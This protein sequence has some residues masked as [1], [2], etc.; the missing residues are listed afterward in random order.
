M[1]RGFIGSIR[2]WTI[3]ESK[4]GVAF[5]GA[6]IVAE[7]HGRAIAANLNARLVGVYDPE[8]NRA[9]A[10]AKK[11]GAKAFGSIEEALDSPQVSAVHVLTPP[12]HHMEVALKSLKAGKH[13]LVEK[14]VAWRIADIKRLRTAAKRANRACMPAHNYIYNPSLQRAKR[15]IDENRL[16]QI[17]SLWVLYNIYHSEEVASRYG[18]VLRAVCVHHAYSLLYLLGR[19]RR[20]MAT[21]SKV[22]YRRLVCEDQVM[23][24]CEMP[25]GAIANLWCSFAAKDLTSDPWL[26]VYK[27]LGTEGSVNYTWN[28]AQ[29]QDD[30]GPG[31]GLPCYED[32]FR[33]EVDHFINRCV[34]EGEPPLSTLTEAIDA[35]RII[36]A[37]ERSCRHHTGMETID[38]DN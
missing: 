35:L 1:R 30:R 33:N 21:A 15:L 18:G 27:I 8:A 9:K 28:E 20:L 11:F 3:P 25:N 22:H 26:V 34:L 13:V 7:M 29:F 36:E 16:G 32:G 31:W 23:I 6:G 38:Y 4:I 14:P 5:A 2:R 19:P 17:A 37:A 24:V 10:V 12:E